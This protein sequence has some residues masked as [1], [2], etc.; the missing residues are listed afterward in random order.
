MLG[1]GL[2]GQSSDAP[3]PITTADEARQVAASK[4]GINA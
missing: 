4:T 1:T 3:S 2:K